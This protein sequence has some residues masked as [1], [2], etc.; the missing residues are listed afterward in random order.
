MKRNFLS[1]SY[2]ISEEPRLRVRMSAPGFGV[3]QTGDSQQLAA[4][5][6]MYENGSGL[7]RWNVWVF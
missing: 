6:F 5:V 4:S 7:D 2:R 3:R 1:L